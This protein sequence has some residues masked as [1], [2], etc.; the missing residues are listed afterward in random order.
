LRDKLSPE[1]ITSPPRKKSKII[2]GS[3][4]ND[5]KEDEERSCSDDIR[6]KGGEELEAIATQNNIEEE[7]EPNLDQVIDNIQVEPIVSI[8]PIGTIT[9]SIVISIESFQSIQL[10]IELV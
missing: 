3:L 2:F 5:L 8:E 4:V 1:P 10:E 7:L 9:E 6:G